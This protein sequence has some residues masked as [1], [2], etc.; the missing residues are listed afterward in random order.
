VNN[1][2]AYNGEE[3]MVCA[4]HASRNA[5]AACYKC[6][7]GMCQDCL[8]HGY[9]AM[10]YN[11]DGKHL[12]IN[13]KRDELAQARRAKNVN[14][15]K[16][17]FNL[18]F[19]GIG[20]CA[21][22]GEGQIINYVVLASIGGLPSAW[23]MTGGDHNDSDTLEGMIMSLVLRVIFAFIFGSILAPFT[24]IGS[25]IGYLKDKSRIARLE[26]QIELVEQT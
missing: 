25:V 19:V 14:L 1:Q 3:E 24:I 18:V 13:C 5:V 12:C 2:R 26:Q 8:D 22:I 17:V 21:W 9:N 6:G 10:E 7:A 23:K 20:L 16:F 11:Y 15:F 4:I